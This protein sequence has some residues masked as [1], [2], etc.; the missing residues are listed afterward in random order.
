[1]KQV[2][3]REATVTAYTMEGCHQFLGR[4]C[5][6]DMAVAIPA[7]YRRLQFAFVFAYLITTRS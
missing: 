1:M 3:W 2:S 5:P 7:L 4:T 6:A